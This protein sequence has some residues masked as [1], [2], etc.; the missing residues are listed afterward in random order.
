MKELKLKIFQEY[1][2]NILGIF[3]KTI[4]KAVKKQAGVA[5]V[6]PFAPSCVCKHSLSQ[7]KCV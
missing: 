5:R 1:S 6:I 4:T 7:G 2:K 3:H